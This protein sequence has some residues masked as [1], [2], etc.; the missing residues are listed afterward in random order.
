MITVLIPNYGHR[1]YLMNAVDSILQQTYQDFEIII[2]NDDAES[3]KEY[4]SIDRRI[5][6]H[7]RVDTQ[8]QTS[9]ERI[10]AIV[11]TIESQC[12]A[13]MEADGYAYPKRLEMS[14]HY[15]EKTGSDIITTDC[16][17]LHKIFSNITRRYKTNQNRD[18]TGS[19]LTVFA[20]SYVFK[21]VPFRKHGYGSD[22]IWF[23]DISNYGYSQGHLNLPLSIHLDYESRFRKFVSVPIL[24]KLYR[25]LFLKSQITRFLKEN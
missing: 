15:L 6:V 8:R 16:I 14:L 2:L 18:N 4:E 24:R 5:T 17:Y 11:P 22:N 9:E 19:L 25:V 7:D 21:D 3:L 13:Y 12:I 20:C 10:N 23:R 1:R